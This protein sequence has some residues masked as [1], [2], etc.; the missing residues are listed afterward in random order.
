MK[1]VLVVALVLAVASLANASIVYQINGTNYTG[2]A[3]FAA[4][5]GAVTVSLYNTA[6]DALAPDLGGIIA[7]GGTTGFTGSTVYGS[8]LA[9][10]WS[11]IPLGFLQPA[12]SG[13]SYAGYIDAISNDVPG[14]TP[15]LAG[16][17]FDFTLFVTGTTTVQMLD[18]NF[19]AKGE[20]LT[21]NVVPEPMTMTL[22]GLG[23]LLLRRKK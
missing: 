15:T 10:T 19:G 9:G 11:V 14:V 23:G 13:A 12:D 7:A 17:L 5:Q 8:N 21:L 4:A 22:L 2:G 18:A 6:Q 16:K 20:A 1:K 3:V